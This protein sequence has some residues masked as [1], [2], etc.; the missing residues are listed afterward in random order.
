MGRAR[1]SHELTLYCTRS[2]TSLLAHMPFLSDAEAPACFTSFWKP[3]TAS[4]SA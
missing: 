1:G 4:L 3:A 2:S